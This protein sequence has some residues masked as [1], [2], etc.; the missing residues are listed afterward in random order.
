MHGYLII[1]G[2]SIKEI[3]NVFG[4]KRVL[5]SSGDSSSFDV[6]FF[7]YLLNTQR[8][9]NTLEIIIIYLHNW[10]IIILL[11]KKK[12]NWAVFEYLFTFFYSEGQWTMWKKKDESNDCVKEKIIVKKKKIIGS[13]NVCRQSYGVTCQVIDGK[14]KYI[15]Q[16]DALKINN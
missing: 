9:C 5:N 11:K 6:F 1:L 2:K 4:R 14:N 8:V 13:S 3:K 10:K 15:V 16:L 7:F 12:E